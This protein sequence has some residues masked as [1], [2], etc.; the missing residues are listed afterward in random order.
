MNTT[1]ELDDFFAEVE[2]VAVPLSTDGDLVEEMR[3]LAT[4]RSRKVIL[5]E[6]LKKVNT[7]I[8]RSSAIII[9]TYDARGIS[10]MALEGVGLFYTQASPYPSV[11]NKPAFIAWL[12]SQGLSELAVRTVNFMTLRSEWKGWLAKG[13][14]LPP[15]EL[16]SAILDR[17]LRVRKG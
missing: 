3:V 1:D 17:Q 8:K 14:P 2:Q 5:E 13:L 10:K 9:A 4:L 6:E 15:E 11:H 7:E 16:A 12:D